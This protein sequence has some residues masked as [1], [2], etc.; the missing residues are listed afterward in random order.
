MPELQVN[1]IYDEPTIARL[2]RSLS[3][4]R[5]APY[6]ELADGDRRYAI[7][8]YEWNTR[9]CETMYSILQGFEVTLRNAFHET[10]RSA[11]RREDWYE[12]APLREYEKRLIAAA[13][14][15]IEKDGRAIT[16][17]RVVAELM[18]GFWTSL[19]GRQY[20]QTIWDQFLH[21]AFRSTHVGRK[22]ISE[23]LKKIRFL[24]NRV[25]HHE[26]IIGRKNR[27]RDLRKEVDEIIETASWICPTTAKWIVLTSSFDD[28]YGKRPHPPEAA[29][30][31]SAGQ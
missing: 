21:A 3:P 20:A 13:K 1:L 25:A 15:R 17:G 6:L 16:P 22:T 27:E 2:E 14:E 30:P 24:R 23:R 19:T 9:A 31:F 18:F 8:L 12:I 29:L 5:L 7:A 28:N 26:S 4:E 11:L 10:M